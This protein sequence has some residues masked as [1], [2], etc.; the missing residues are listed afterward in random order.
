MDTNPVTVAEVSA[1]IA[2]REETRAELLRALEHWRE[3][4]ERVQDLEQRLEACSEGSS[5]VRL[6]VA[7]PWLESLT[8]G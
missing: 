8:R 6:R 1:L 5:H 2:A 7:R 4:E 3:I